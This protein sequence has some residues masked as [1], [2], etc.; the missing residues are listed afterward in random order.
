MKKFVMC[1]LVQKSSIPRHN[2]PGKICPRFSCMNELR[3][4]RW[5]KI[6]RTLLVKNDILN[7]NVAETG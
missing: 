6:K 4:L 7:S 3:I 1:L 2:F 5:S